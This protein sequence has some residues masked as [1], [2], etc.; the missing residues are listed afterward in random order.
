[1]KVQVLSGWPCGAQAGD[2]LQRRPCHG[3]AGAGKEK[4]AL[5]R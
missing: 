1:M 5:F 4:L 2:G 3:P